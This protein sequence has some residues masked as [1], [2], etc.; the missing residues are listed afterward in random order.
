[1]GQMPDL[2]YRIRALD[3]ALNVLEA[4]TSEHPE[5]DLDAICERTQ[6]PKSTVFKILAVLQARGYV[7]KSQANGKYRIGF[8]AYE[9]GNRYL[10]GLT[11]F[12]VV[13]P[14]LKELAARFPT[15]SAHL[16]VLSPTET[17]IVY[18][19]IVSLNIYL[20]LVPVGSHYPAHSTALG[21]CLLASLP[22]P[23]LERRLAQIS[24]PRL[25]PNTVTDLATLREQLE[26]IRQQGYSI[27]DEETS[28]G[29][30]CVAFPV[31]DRRGVT[32]A[33]ISTSHVKELMHDDLATVIAEMRHAASKINRS[34]GY[35]EPPASNKT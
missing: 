12:E 7:E 29:Y 21:K 17:R 33:A 9:V 11:V 6:L 20:S 30:L 25:T 34:L 1:M 3:R 14:V 2:N 27:D 5:L 15:S 31:L 28:L 24:M 23:E 16:A 10:A 13:H 22:E 18:L 8:Q 19:D 35:V 32:I 26:Q 4:F